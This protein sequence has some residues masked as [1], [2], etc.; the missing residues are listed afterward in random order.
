MPQIALSSMQGSVVHPIRKLCVLPTCLSQPLRV[1]E[2]LVT[3]WPLL[4]LDSGL[5]AIIVPYVALI[6]YI[7][8]T[9]L[10]QEV[11]RIIYCPS[12]HHVEVRWS[13]FE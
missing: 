2:L 11:D 7:T 10:L 5:F 6:R 13:S 8:S 1:H 12:I 3:A 9:F 4:I